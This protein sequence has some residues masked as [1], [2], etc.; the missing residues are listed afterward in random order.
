MSK[1][2]ILAQLRG[3]V[4][5]VIKSKTPPLHESLQKAHEQLGELVAAA[6]SVETTDVAYPFVGGIQEV[7]ARLRTFE[8]SL[9]ENVET[10]PTWKAISPHDFLQGAADQ[11]QKALEDADVA[12]G[13]R[14]LYNLKGIIGKAES[15][16]SAGGDINVPVFVD[17][18]QYMWTE[19]SDPGAKNAAG[20][21]SPS[22]AQSNFA[23]NPTDVGSAAA[24]TTNGGTG[25]VEGL[26]GGTTAPSTAA[27]N[28]SLN[29][30]DVLK[31]LQKSMQG[32]KEEKVFWTM[33]LNHPRFMSGKGPKEDFGVDPWAK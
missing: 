23:D 33:D 2:E 15:F 4:V 32:G 29:P 18:W 1:A 22:T 14:R 17:P 7:I 6:K 9:A 10:T 13:L 16:E 3:I 20:V 31:N 28:F 19:A 8:S 5:G 12:R 30:G 11:V 25:A 24:P 27:S 21:S 26:A